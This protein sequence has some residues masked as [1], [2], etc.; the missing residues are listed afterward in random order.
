[1]LLERRFGFRV[2]PSRFFANFNEANWISAQK[3]RESLHNELWPLLGPQFGARQE[4]F[5]NFA[6]EFAHSFGHKSIERGHITILEQLIS[7][8]NSIKPVPTQLTH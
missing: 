7:Q 3:A 2:K 4:S 1:M 6:L 5:V 8:A